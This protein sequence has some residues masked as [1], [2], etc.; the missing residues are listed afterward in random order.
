MDD[1]GTEDGTTEISWVQ[2]PRADLS[3][4]MVESL[5]YVELKLEHPNLAPTSYGE[6]FFP[7]AVPYEFDGDY[8]VF[9]WRPT[10]DTG[11]SE[12]PDWQGVCA[13]T[14]TLSVVEKGRPYT[15]EFVSRRAETEVVV[16]GTIGGDSTTAVVR[17]YSAPDVRIREVTASRLELLADGTEYTVSSGTR[18]RISLS[19]Q[20]VERADGDGTMAVTP[21][22][23]V[24]FP[25]EREL[26]HPA[27]GAEY[28]LFPSFGLELDTVSNPAPVPTTNGELDH[29]AFATSLGV[30]LSD[31]PYPERVLWQ[32]FAYTAFDPHTETVPRLTQFRTGHLALLN[33]PPES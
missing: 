8:R 25:G 30:D 15:P 29:A 6:S 11:T 23:V 4:P 5:P 24:R 32:A 7:D 2:S 27:P 14:D 18:R 3:T 12:Q 31:R 28:R 19:E 21:E 1:T 9:Y 33:S 20:T 26:H 17:S 13:T 22:L 10:L 16:E